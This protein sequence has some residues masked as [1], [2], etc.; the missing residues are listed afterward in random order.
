[1]FIYTENT[2]D[3]LL[4]E[5]YLII[6]TS[7]VKSTIIKDNL[8]PK[9][10]KVLS[11]P[12][13]SRK[14][15]N[16]V[17]AYVNR[18]SARLTTIGP[19]YLVPFTNND[20]NMYYELFD[21][22]E[23]EIKKLVVQVTKSVNDKAN[24]LFMKNNPIF[25]L[26][27][28]VVRYFTIHKDPKQLNNALVI[29][30]LSYYPSSYSKYFKFDPNAGVMHYTIDSLS[31]RFIIKKSNHVFGMLAYSIQGSWKFHEKDFYNGNDW[32]VIRF[33]QRIRNDQNSLLKKI[34]N[35]YMENH[36]KG[37]SIY[38]QVDQYDDSVVVDN[39]NDTNKVESVTNKIVTNMII[40]GV[41]LKLCDFAANAAVVS[42][43][44]LRNYLTK[45]QTEK[46][47]KEMMDFIESILF[48]YLYDGKYT[49]QD[50][51]S[52]Q[53]VA[54][55]IQL[56]KKTNSKDKNITNVK[57]TL[58]KWGE[59]SGIYGRFARLATRVDYTKA[60][61]LYFIASIQKYA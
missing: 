37:L 5:D 45:I 23:D 60:I 33:I 49:F 29:M 59:D 3:R 21:T 38:T 11:T 30:A 41:D 58:D 26:F 48:L 16:L 2:F 52:K 8:Y 47:S 46:K 22:S 9:V 57:T 14:F 51:N 12:E 17:G 34:A 36:K 44:E 53:F 61:F 13:G 4:N 50:I 27:Y 18:N 43:M 6:E 25:T 24:W 32:E 15:A 1:M 7:D 35:N 31:Q 10:E 20:K 42:K 39:E 28:C 56:F 40:N 19:M 54:F 55:A